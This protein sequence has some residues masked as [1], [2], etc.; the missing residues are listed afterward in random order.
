MVKVV[1]VNFKPAGKIYYFDPGDLQVKV[2]DHVIVET[3]RGTEFGTINMAEKEI[4]KSE[5]VSPLKK[6]IRIAD[7]RDHKRH[8][9]KSGHCVCVRRKLT[10]TNW[11]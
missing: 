3:A 11:K 2:G 4:S 9:T 1:G 6:I 5:I 8:K 10:N 7:E